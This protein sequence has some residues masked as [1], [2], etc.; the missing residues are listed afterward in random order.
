MNR[1]AA[2][3]ALTACPRRRRVV[4]RRTG[5]RRSPDSTPAMR[6]WQA[7]CATACCK[8][9]CGSISGSTASSRGR[10]S[11]SCATSCVWRFISSGFPTKFPPLRRSTRRW[12]RQ[13]ALQNPAAARFVNGAAQLFALSGTARAAGAFRPIQPPGGADRAAGQGIRRRARRAPASKPQRGTRDGFAGQHAQD[14]SAVACARIGAGGVQATPHLWLE[15]CLTVR[16]TG[17]LERL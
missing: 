3:R 2:L 1:D 7:V 12:S 13:S 9:G 10:P 11:R 8:T 5:S 14:R 4:G 17:S 15:N 16:G 6:R